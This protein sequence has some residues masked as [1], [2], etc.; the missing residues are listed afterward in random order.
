MA[1]VVAVAD[2]VEDAVADFDSMVLI[3]FVVLVN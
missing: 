2:V 1:V 3:P